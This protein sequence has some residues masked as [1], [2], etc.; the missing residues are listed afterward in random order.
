MIYQPEEDIAANA[1]K[2]DLHMV[3]YSLIE[4]E[5]RFTELLI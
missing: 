2:G 3:L 1:G 4:I 5:E